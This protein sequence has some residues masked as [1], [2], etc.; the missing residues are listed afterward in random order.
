MPGR[1]NRAVMLMIKRGAAE[2]HHSDG[3]ALHA[4][5]IPLLHRGEWDWL[6]R[7]FEMQAQP[8]PYT[9]EASPQG[10]TRGEGLGA[11]FV[12]A[13]PPHHHAGTPVLPIAYL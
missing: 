3:C 10:T 9:A 8:F 6:L 2:V 13:Q 4:P 12:L 7:S 5:L 1:D 11:Y